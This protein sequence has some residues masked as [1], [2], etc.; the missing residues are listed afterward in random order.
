MKN[1]TIFFI[2]FYILLNTSVICINERMVKKLSKIITKETLESE[3]LNIKSTIKEYDEFNKKFNNLLEEEK[4]A[5]EEKNYDEKKFRNEY[6]KLLNEAE[7]YKNYFFIQRSKM[8][9][10]INKPTEKIE[11]KTIDVYH[12]TVEY[13]LECQDLIKEI[14][15]KVNVDKGDL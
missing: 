15:Q 2:L 13:S 9:N 10:L 11:Q 12:S 6:Q 1:L 8:S 7:I 14:E 4:K 5:K 3:I